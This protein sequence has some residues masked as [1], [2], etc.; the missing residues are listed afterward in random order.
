MKNFQQRMLRTTGHIFPIKNCTESEH[1]IHSCFFL[2]FFIQKWVHLWRVLIIQRVW[3]TSIYANSRVAWCSQC[4]F[5]INYYEF[6]KTSLITTTMSF[7]H[8][9]MLGNGI[10]WINYYSKKNCSIFINKITFHDV[11]CPFAVMNALFIE[12][13]DFLWHL[14]KEKEEEDILRQQW[15]WTNNVEKKQTT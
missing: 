7:F 6:T 4:S 3:L 1:F 15:T 12:C 10:L 9:S 5:S 11:R 8:V 14:F 2:L 13:S